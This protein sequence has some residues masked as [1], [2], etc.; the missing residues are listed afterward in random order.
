MGKTIAIT[1]V[2]G[3]TASTLLPLLETA[4][5]IDKII[6][7]DV[8]PW[9]GGFSKVEFFRE[10]IRVSKISGILEHTDVVCHLA[11][12][13]ESVHDRRIADDIHMNGLEN[14]LSA[15]EKNGIRKII[16]G[17]CTSVYGFLPPPAT[18]FSETDAVF[19]RPADN[20]FTETAGNLEMLAREFMRR[21]PDVTVTF[22]R[23][24]PVTGPNMDNLLEKALCMQFS[25]LPAKNGGSL[26]FIHE[27]D[28]GRALFAAVGKEIPG[29]YN[30]GANDV[31]P[32]KSCFKQAGVKMLPLPAW[33]SELVAELGFRLRIYPFGRD[34]IRLLGKS[35]FADNEKFQ[36]AGGWQPAYDSEAAFSTFVKGS[37]ERKQQDNHLQA[38]LSW[39]IKSGKRLK[40]FLP[41]LATFRIGR[42]PG[43]RA[44]VP[45]LNPAKNSINYLPV[46]ESITV[47]GNV[48]PSQVVHDLIESAAIH[49]IMDK[50]GCRMLR[51][52]QHYTQNIGCLFMG[53]TALK[54]PHGVCRRVSK[55][56][57]HAHAARAMALGLLPMTG[58]VRIDNFIYMTPDRGKLLSLCFCCDCCCILTSYK[59][60]PGPY[61]DGIIQPINGLTVE[62]TDDCV[63]CGVCIQTCAFDAI[64]IIDGK[65]VHNSQCRGCGRCERFCPE[66]AVTITIKNTGYADEVNERIRS[67]VNF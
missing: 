48:L 40:P 22:M 51:N 38:V 12:V 61:L 31:L 7:I 34:Y 39:I 62:V 56:S 19:D 65:A 6:G 49:V 52:C 58:K 20:Y 64:R 53:E 59:H 3:Y 17:G 66:K 44:M 60:V 33:L 11:A 37:I 10:D 5:D 9:K 16:I 35:I 28:L 54:L 2:N 27:D 21:H 36:S 67:Y 63:G 4:D 30:V 43:L 18:F 29:I 45:W 42:V 25:M 26:Q 13:G 57:A 32:L 41:V 15:C 14:I 23:I 50:C 55:E 24:A 46:N 8:R 1:G 47:D